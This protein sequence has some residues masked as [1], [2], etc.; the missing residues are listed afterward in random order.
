MI[1]EHM[2]RTGNSNPTLSRVPA[3]KH[4]YNWV[5]AGP[6][7]RSPAE[8][9]LEEDRSGEETEEDDMTASDFSEDDLME[10]ERDED[11]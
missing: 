10:R 8:A 11:V 1:E 4:A 5:P 3:P 7:E 9:E 6:S 2:D